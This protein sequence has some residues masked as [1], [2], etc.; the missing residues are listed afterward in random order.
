MRT[1]AQLTTAVLL[2]LGFLRLD[3]S[4]T[5][6]TVL[7][8]T[9]GEMRT[10]IKDGLGLAKPFTL[11]SRPDLLTLQQKMMTNLGFALQVGNPPPG[12]MDQLRNWLNEAQDILWRRIELGQAGISYP[13]QMLNPTDNTTLDGPVVLNQAMAM[14]AAHYGRPDAQ[15]W[16]AAVEKYLADTTQRNPPNIDEHINTALN[17]AQQIVISRYQLTGLV[18]NSY[19][20]TDSDLSAMDYVPIQNLALSMI[21]ERINQGGAKEARMVYEQYM[22]DVERRMPANAVQ[23]VKQYLEDAQRTLYHRYDVFRVERFFTWTCVPGQN[24][25]DFDQNDEQTADPPCADQAD[26]RHVYWMGMQRSDGDYWYPLICGIPPEMY[27]R[28]ITSYWPSRYEI[29][30]CIEIWPAPGTD[31]QKIRM[32]AQVALRAFAADDDEA[33]IDDHAIYLLALANTKAYFGQKD[34]V[35]YAGSRTSQLEVYIQGLVGGSHMTARYI[36]G[37]GVRANLYVEPR[38]SVPFPP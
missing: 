8:R 38:P 30:K 20:T 33:T 36:P 13:T 28:N 23:V 4:S 31:V 11:V 5:D 18:P 7:K 22:A 12:M 3:P 34:A 17:D 24:L 19:M 29:R 10:A 25:Y 14:A 1:F 6:L 26:P 16:A 15:G 21:R 27:S 2:G 9:R 32:K 37:S 35:V